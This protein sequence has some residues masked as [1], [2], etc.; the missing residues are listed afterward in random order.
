MKQY[1]TLGKISTMSKIH[2]C[3]DCMFIVES[4][5]IENKIGGLASWR[6]YALLGLNGLTLAL[7][8]ISS[9]QGSWV[10]HGSC[11]TQMG[12][13]LAPWTLLSGYVW[14]KWFALAIINPDWDVVGSRSQSSQKTKSPFILYRHFNTDGLVTQDGI[15]S[16]AISASCTLGIFWLQ[17]LKGH[18]CNIYL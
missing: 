10:Q 6:I 17:E 16:I 2:F 12:P 8:N 9:Q 1:W 3:I 14:K 5:L 13:I 18:P 7:Q 11:R 15:A 4:A